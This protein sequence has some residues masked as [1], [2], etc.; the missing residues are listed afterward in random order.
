[1][2]WVTVAVTKRHGVI[3][4]IRAGDGRFRWTCT[5]GEG[6]QRLWHT[7]WLALVESNDHL[8]G[9]VSTPTVWV[10]VRTGVSKFM[11]PH[12]AWCRDGTIGVETL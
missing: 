10:M 7:E 2:A 8:R 3:R 5:C 6:A 4:L 11:Q 1:M 12:K 9:V